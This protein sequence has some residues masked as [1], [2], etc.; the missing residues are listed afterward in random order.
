MRFLFYMGHPAHYHN[1]S[2]VMDQLKQ[3]GHEILTVGREKDVLLD[4]MQ[5]VPYSKVF[6]PGKRGNS[7][8]V[9]ITSVLKRQWQMIKLARKFKP[10]LMIGTDIVI[11]HVGKLLGIP[12][13]ILNED[14]TDQIP[15]FTKYGIRFAS[16][17]LSPEPCG[18]APY[19]YKTYN[20]PGYHEL[21]YL[22]PDHFKPERDKIKHLFGSQNRYFLIRFSAL[23]S[24]HDIGKKGISNDLAMQLID[25][26]KAHGNV[27]VS[28]E[29][30]K[31]LP[32]AFAPYRIAIAPKDMHHALYFSDLY[33]GDSQTMAAEAAVL[34]T[35]SIRFNDFV[36]KL[37][38]LEEL[39]HKFALTYGIPTN[40]PDKLVAKVE[41]LL[42]IPDLKAKWLE[43][44]DHMLRETIDVARFMTWFFETFPKERLNIK[45]TPELLE[46]FKSSSGM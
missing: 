17:V 31:K 42:A 36:G 11:T 37:G 32:D 2:V 29:R 19:E 44:R 1:V 30:E 14:D 41:E 22:H 18:D 4:L 24:H 27:F 39:E 33:I 46:D 7:K 8:F 12:T 20:Y 9:L 28:A 25:L 10:D 45:V 5:E 15:F 13:V 34:G 3:K 35:P 6:L 38:Y 40:Q 43:K 21:A 16:T 23:E 26:L